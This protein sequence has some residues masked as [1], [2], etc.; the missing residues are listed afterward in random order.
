MDDILVTQSSMP[1]FEEYVEEIRTIW[2]SKWL[3]N[4]GPKHQELE[5]KIK[6]QM[7]TENVELLVNGHMA[8][9][10]SLQALNLKGE[11]ITT[12]FTFV[13]TVHAIT[14]NGLTPVFCDIN[15][16]DFTINVAEIERHITEKT[17]AIMP[18][19]VYGNICNIE[20]IDRIAQKYNLKVIYDAAHCFGEEYNGINV[21]NYGDVSCYSFH[22]TKVFQTIEG[23]A[24][25]YRDKKFGEALR[26][27]KNFGIDGERIVAIGCNAKM[28]EF[29]AAMGL[30]NLKHLDKEILK[31][32]LV[33]ERYSENLNKISGIVTRSIQKKVK[34]NYA[35]YPII[36]D[37]NSYG[38]TR[39]ELYSYLEQNGIH[40]RKY[41]YPAINDSEA[42]NGMC[43]SKMTPVAHSISEQVLTLPLY[44]DLPMESVDRICELIIQFGKMR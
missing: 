25:C 44:A 1:S 41:F 8:L 18:V 19:H 28:N 31:R 36:I 5:Q 14:R 12:P 15:S 39:D 7:Q 17:C 27:L 42:Y 30:C 24:V 13:S 40:S 38:H 33:Y 22:A 21:G 43:N 2:D 23:G 6:E 37:K 16:N 11:V 35:Y 4:M 9:E 3:T 20:E 26:R 10:L 34:S 29:A 32:K